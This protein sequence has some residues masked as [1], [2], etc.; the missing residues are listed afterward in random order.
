MIGEGE[1]AEVYKSIDRRDQKDC[2]VKKLKPPVDIYATKH[3]IDLLQTLRGGP[4]IVQFIGAATDT[5]RSSLGLVTEYVKGTAWKKL[6]PKL[7][8][9]DI[10]F[11]SFQLLRAL[12]HA[13][14]RNIM[15]RDLKPDNVVIEHENHK[16]SGRMGLDFM[17]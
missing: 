6:Y 11:Y 14:A 17:C 4:N 12:E 15:H 13:H 16:V 1:Y 10:Q 3:E 8:N 7:S 5:D 9:H 2:V